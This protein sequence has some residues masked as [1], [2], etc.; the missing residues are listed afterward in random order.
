MRVIKI[1]I[2]LLFLTLKTTLIF[3]QQ[4]LDLFIKDSHGNPLPYTSVIWARSTGLVSNVDGFIQIPDK[5]KIDSLFVSA[6][7]YKNKI[8]YREDIINRAR[9]DISLEY[10][11]IQLPEVIIAKYNEESVFGVEEK[12]E[13]SYIKNGICTNLQGALLIKSYNYPAQCR[14]LSVF[15]AKQSTS[16]IPYRLR[17]YEVGNDGLPGNDLLTES[18]IV[19]SYNTNAWNTYELDSTIV[20]LPKN[21]FFVAIEWLCIDLKSDNGLCIGLSSKKDESLTYY[22]YGNV[23]WIQ[24]RYKTSISKDNLMIKATIASVK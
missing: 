9:I 7:G 16:T 19:N 8:L 17:L 14:S 11:V 6:I 22:K 21:G 4:S 13:T 3:S 10:S 2:I 15:I 1:G 12:R 20:Q 5:S 18:L 24:L 23:G